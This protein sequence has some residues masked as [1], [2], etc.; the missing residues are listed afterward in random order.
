MRTHL[1][2]LLLLGSVFL[3]LDTTVTAAFGDLDPSFSGD[4]KF[5]NPSA[6]YPEGIARQS[7]GKILV[8]GRANGPAI[9]RRYNANGTVDTTFGSNGNAVFYNN[10]AW[11]RKVVVL[12]DGK[13]LV[14]GQACSFD[15]SAVWRFNPDGWYDSSFGSF[16]R[17][18]FSAAFG[19]DL[20]GYKPTRT[21]PQDLLV[22]AGYRL[23]RLGPSGSVNT[24]FGI[25]GSIEVPF[26]YRLA[27]RQ[28][29]VYVSGSVDQE[30]K[31]AKYSATDGSIDLSFGTM[32]VFSESAFQNCGG[33]L[34]NNFT[35]YSE[36]YDA[37][38]FQSDGKIIAAGSFTASNGTVQ[39]E[40]S[41]VNRHD[42]DGGFDLSFPPTCGYSTPTPQGFVDSLK[43]LPDDR[44]L[45]NDWYGS[46]M[47]RLT[48]DGLPDGDFP[49]SGPAGGFVVEP[50]GKIV[51]VGAVQVVGV[52]HTRVSRYLP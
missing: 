1:L 26:G 15:C 20:V 32:G 25:G 35:L 18:T 49:T 38:G 42:P 37:I 39:T 8:V 23:Y 21:S 17:V 6:F 3:S 4:G 34:P 46:R 7:D 9:L 10:S 48:A 19:L 16:G 22:L 30:A 14:Q 47:Y 27:L 31:I 51:V 24:S 12:G 33:S 28:S 36:G 29:S 43:V 13:I 5:T 50:S 45:Y 11:P 41:L 2:S 40:Y 52:W 44:I